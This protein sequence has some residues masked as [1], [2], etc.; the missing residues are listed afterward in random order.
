MNTP[1]LHCYKKIEQKLHW[2][3]KTLHHGLLKSDWDGL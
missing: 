3:E 2:Q 1:V